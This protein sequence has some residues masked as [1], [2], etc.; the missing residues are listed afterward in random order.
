MDDGLNS[1]EN[2]LNRREFV[3]LALMSAAL[4]MDSSALVEGMETDST[5]HAFAVLRCLAPGAVQP[6]GWLRGYMERQAAQLGSKL[7]QVSLPFTEAYWAG[8]ENAVSLAA[9]EQKGYWIDG[10]TRLSVVLQD[11]QLMAQVRT[12]IDYTLAHAMADGYLGPKYFED[13]KGDAHRWPQNVFFR[14]LAALCDAKPLPGGPDSFNIPEALRKHYLFDKASYG[15]PIRNVTNIEAMLWCYKK[16]GDPGLLALAENAWREYMT[17]AAEREHGDLSALRVFADTP[18]DAHGVTYAEI[19]K[20]PAILYLHTGEDKYLQFALAAERRIFDHHMLIDGIP[21]ASE[22]YRTVTA[23]DSHETCDITDHTWSWGYMLMATGNAVWADR[24]E[25]ACFNAAPGAIKN[26]WKAL[27]Y[28]S[29]PNQFLATLNSNHNVEGH[30]NRLMAYQ[31]NPG[32]HTACCG[33]NV[34]RIF[35]NYVIRMWM[36]TNDGGLAAVL[37]GPSKVNAIVG[38]DRRKVEIVQKTNYPFDEQIQFKINADGAVTFPLSLRIPAWCDEPRLTVNGKA[39]AASRSER[40]FLVLRRRFNPGDQVT[41]ILPMKVAI[42]RWPENGMGVERGPLVYS[43]PIKVNWTSLVEPKYTTAE[44]PSWEALPASA[45]NYGILLDPLQLA[46][47]V[48]VKRR[49][50]VENGADDPWENPPITLTVP[51]K[52]IEGWELQSNLDDLSQKFTSCLPDLSVSKINETVERVS[53]VPYGSTQLRVT[54]FPTLH[55]SSKVD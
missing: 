13:P 46:S 53:L 32:Q 26:D 44:F 2:E 1:A 12:A 35:P 24:V 31:P 9:W 29:C 36:E 43:L 19:M 15:T 21:S 49:P 42:T 25:R 48:E 27:Q 45:W 38:P 41:L 8:E 14:S 40:G 6:E 22:H 20:L 17:V 33:G 28:F 16:T 54:I 34:H 23:L 55:G 3:R 11:E 51:A 18:T 39:V 47:Q 5:S 52:R 4:L 50:L 37:Y 7:P 30:G 10:A